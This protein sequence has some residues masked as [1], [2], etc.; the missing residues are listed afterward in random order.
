MGPDSSGSMIVPPVRVRKHS[1]V[2][3][4]PNSTLTVDLELLSVAARRER[5]GKPVVVGKG[6]TP[7]ADREEERGVEGDSS[8]ARPL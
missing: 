4:P 1:G 2:E 5:V 8:A 7:G 6:R 3:I